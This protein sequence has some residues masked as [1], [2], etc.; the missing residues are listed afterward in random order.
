MSYQHDIFISYRR[1]SE[2]YDWIKE[3]FVPLLTLRVEFELRRKPHV[4]LDDQ[5]E[6][7]TSWPLS[8]GTALGTS[9]VLI[10]LWSGNYRASAW[11]MHE[12]S[13]ML[14]REKQSKLRT[15]DHPHGVVVPAFIHDGPE[16]FPSELSYIQ[17]FDIHNSFNPRMA[18]NSPRAEELDAILAAQAPSIS[19]CINAA[20]PW[21]RAWSKQAAKDFFTQFYQNVEAV[22]RTV[23]RFTKP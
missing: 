14:A 4:Y 12:F 23:P 11:C 5:I 20:P 3:N 13:H 17:H 21:R 16:T 10:P 6:S 8:L 7:G 2:T 1:N 15:V 22:Q 19:A 18:R 9:R